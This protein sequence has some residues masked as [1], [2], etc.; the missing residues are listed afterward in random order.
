MTSRP[1]DLTQ[2]ARGRR[3]PALANAETAAPPD[4]VPVPHTAARAA[5]PL[6]R[7]GGN[8]TEH[9]REVTALISARDDHGGTPV[10]RPANQPPPSSRARQASAASRARRSPPSTDA[11]PDLRARPRPP[12]TPAA[13]TPSRCRSDQPRMRRLDH[14]GART[15]CRPRRAGRPASQ[16]RRP[17]RRGASMTVSL[18]V[19]PRASRE[20]APQVGGEH[21]HR[22]SHG[23]GALTVRDAQSRSG[24]P[25]A[26][27]RSQ[28]PI[29]S[30]EPSRAGPIVPPS[31]SRGHRPERL[32]ASNRAAFHDDSSYLGRS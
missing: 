30:V 28:V 31:Q 23:H 8:D 27:G 7:A 26:P 14:Q 11:R 4:Q 9:G 5:S 22:D 6:R 10:A 25:S 15:E 29:G 12:G 24:T 16:R 2:P 20:S 32:R 17:S 1:G 13:V 3:T 19:P 21:G 18:M